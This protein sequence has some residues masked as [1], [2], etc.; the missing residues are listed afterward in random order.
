MAL[1]LVAAAVLAGCTAA[2]GVATPNSPSPGPSAPPVSNPKDTSGFQPCALLTA[3]QAAD[4]GLDQTRAKAG[5][6]ADLVDCSWPSTQPPVSS[7]AMTIDTNPTRG[8]LADTYLKRNDFKLFEPLLIDGYP[9]VR[10]ERVLSNDCTIEVGLSDTQEVRVDANALSP[11][12]ACA[13]VKRAI[14]VMLT[15]L[16]PQR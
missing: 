5:S 14:S 15:N 3:T 12:D 1:L 7:V 13:L 2:S 6:T 16:P 4:L 11:T 10:A 9:A 8:G